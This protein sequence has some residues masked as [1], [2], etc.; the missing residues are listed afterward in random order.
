MEE[1]TKKQE[2]KGI[3]FYYIKWKTWKETK[4]EC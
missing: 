1:Y 2:H 4:H 3:D